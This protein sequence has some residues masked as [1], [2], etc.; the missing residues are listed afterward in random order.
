MA[1]LPFGGDL[2]FLFGGCKK[3]VDALSQS[4]AI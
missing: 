2:A 3:M 4:E 1:K